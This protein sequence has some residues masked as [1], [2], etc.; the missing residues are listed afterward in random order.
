MTDPVI[1]QADREAAWPVRAT[2]YPPWNKDDWMAGLYDDS[3]DIIKAFAKYRHTAQI[4]AAKAARE[5]Q[6]IETAPRDGTPFLATTLVVNSQTGE[7]WWE[8]NVIW[9]TDD[10]GDWD[11]GWGFDSYTHWQPISEPYAIRALSDAG[12]GE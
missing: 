9:A 3:A 1:E 7:Q 12:E 8:P 6:P 5:W 4:A 11:R 10:N 2:S